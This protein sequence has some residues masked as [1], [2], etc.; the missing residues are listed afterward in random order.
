VRYAYPTNITAADKERLLHSFIVL[1][2]GY[3]RTQTAWITRFL[4][5]IYRF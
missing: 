3:M 5:L 2:L 1:L 4:F